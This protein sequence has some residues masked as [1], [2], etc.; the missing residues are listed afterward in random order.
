MPGVGTKI[1]H[2][3][4]GMPDLLTLF[5]MYAYIDGT[6]AISV[7]QWCE[8][9]LTYGQFRMDSQ[10]GF[11]NI[12][13][14][15][16][17]GN[18]LID[19]RS[20]RR[21]ERLRVIEKKFGKV[22]KEQ[23]TATFRVDATDKKAESFF[24]SQRKPDGSKLDVEQI[25]KYKNRALIFDAV[26]RGMK[27]QLATLAKSGKRLKMGEFWED[28]KDWYLEQIITYP[29]DPIGNARG[30]E[31]AFKAFLKDGYKSIIHANTGNDAARIV[32][33]RIEKLL[34]ALWIGNNKPF[35]NEVHRLYTEFIYGTVEFF[36]KET[37]E[38]FRPD[39]FRYIPKGKNQTPRPLEISVGTVWNYL[40]KHLNDAATAGKRDGNY[41]A[42]VEKRPFH[43]RKSPEFSLS[44]ISMDDADLSRRMKGGGTV[45]RYMM[46][47]VASGYWFTPVYSRDALTQ[48]D[49][50]Q[51]FRNMFCELTVMGYPMPGEIEH[52]HHL[53]DGVMSTDD[54]KTVFPF[55]TISSHSRNKRSEHMIKALKWGAA[56]D[57]NHTRG[58]FY[59]KGCYRTP[60]VRAKGDWV[61]QQYDY[62]TIVQDD[63]R[64][65]EQH[66]NSLHPQQKKYPGMTRK[67]VFETRIN[68][69]LP[70]IEK[71]YLYKFIGNETVTT[72]RNNNHLQCNNALYVV[73]DYKTLSR[74]KPG[75][76]DLTAYWIPDEN[77]STDEVYL[78]QGDVYVGRATNVDNIRYNESKFE[79]T[80]QDKA[81]RLAQDK[82]LAQ[83]DKL[84][85]D[86][87]ADVPKLGSMSAEVSEAMAAVQVDVVAPVS[88]NGLET[89][90]PVEEE[91]SDFDD[92]NFAAMA[93]ENL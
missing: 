82:R 14:R 11:L 66:N 80:E 10:R 48:Q 59:G 20:I 12:L 30:F 27:I 37:G 51:C 2:R 87:R 89:V 34:L 88:N 4:A 28:A 63:L 43:F 3:R 81:N 33:Y 90:D 86:I 68:P 75:K 44:K 67:Q 83:F 60:K 92:M 47:D 19:V 8:A 91:Y 74:M 40:K 65:I 41:I 29:C 22:E 21:P 7:N 9:G 76:S 45:H 72:L 23:K 5:I 49:V 35:K 93:I 55:T 73:D 84:T 70:E 38:I 15:S 52:E 85:K 42:V 54:F 13:Q 69:N 71:W 53:V 78:Y 18:T 58:R 24:I 32:S 1:K 26:E 25:S 46:G 17:N 61:E 36:D 6:L 64:D 57:N 77:G 31:R 39:E 16:T 56:H 50:W 62:D 79:E